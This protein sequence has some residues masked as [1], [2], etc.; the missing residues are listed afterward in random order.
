MGIES[1]NNGEKTMEQTIVE[2]EKP[3]GEASKEKTATRY[4]TIPEAPNFKRR[5]LC[6]KPFGI[7]KDII[8]AY[9]KGASKKVDSPALYTICT[10]KIIV[11]KRMIQ[12]GDEEGKELGWINA[13]EANANEWNVHNVYIPSEF[14]EVKKMEGYRNPNDSSPTIIDVDSSSVFPILET[15]KID[16]DDWYRVAPSLSQTGKGMEEPLWVRD[17]NKQDQTIAETNKFAITKRQALK[18]AKTIDAF[19]ENLRTFSLNER[20]G[21]RMEDMLKALQMV[22]LEVMGASNMTQ[23]L[24]DKKRE[25]TINFLKKSPKFAHMPDLFHLELD[26]I[27]RMDNQAFDQWVNRLRLSGKVFEE[28]V[29]NNK[30]TVGMNLNG[31]TQ[32]LYVV[33]LY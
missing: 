4:E 20:R 32:D 15:K 11:G 25:A 33:P 24:D 21:G 28:I 5:I 8:D 17:R 6:T 31:E 1:P 29:N 27:A 16:H 23:L 12:V 30:N 19:T 22:Y 14:R 3:K 10:D 26:D 7:Y 18:F 9:G 13:E 2:G